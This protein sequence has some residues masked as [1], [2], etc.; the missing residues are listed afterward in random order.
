MIF[1]NVVFRKYILKMYGYGILFHLL[2]FFFGKDL[3]T[4]F[5]SINI[6]GHFKMHIYF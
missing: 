4:T 2:L 1:G 3:D 6:S 5:D